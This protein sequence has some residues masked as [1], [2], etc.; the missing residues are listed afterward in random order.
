MIEKKV[1]GIIII[2]II[3]GIVIGMTLSWI[4]IFISI[5][6]FTNNI[7]PKIQIENVVFDINETELISQFNKT[8]DIE[9][10]HQNECFIINKVTTKY[11]D[12]KNNIIVHEN[13]YIENK[14]EINCG[15]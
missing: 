1:N 8:Y 2:C 13:S 4:F 7:L 11:W 5:F 6:K 9:N 12:Y 10:L 15:E 14:T 3:I